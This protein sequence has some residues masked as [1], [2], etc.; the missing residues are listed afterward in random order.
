[1]KRTEDILD[2]KE[3]PTGE[4][5]PTLQITENKQGEITRESEVGQEYVSIEYPSSELVVFYINCI[6]TLL[7]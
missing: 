3:Q 1:M 4:R 2:R 5:A 6:H 7:Q